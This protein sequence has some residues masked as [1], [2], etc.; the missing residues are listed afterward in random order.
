[1]QSDE[2]AS[3]VLDNNSF[4]EWKIRLER[5]CNAALVAYLFNLN[6]ELRV[7]DNSSEIVHIMIHVVILER[8]VDRIKPSK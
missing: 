6:D 1:M 2:N 4:C 8:S 5:I 3:Q 7:Q